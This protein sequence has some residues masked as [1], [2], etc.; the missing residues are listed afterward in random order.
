MGFGNENGCNPLPLQKKKERKSDRAGTGYEDRLS[1]ERP[2]LSDGMKGGGE[3]IREG[4]AR[5]P[6]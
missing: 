6:Y 1:L 4:G 2:C 5:K 3:R